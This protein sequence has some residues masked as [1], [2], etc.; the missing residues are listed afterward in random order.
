MW[1]PCLLLHQDGPPQEIHVSVAHAVAD[2]TDLGVSQLVFVFGEGVRHV[3]DA[4][5]A[6][7]ILIGVTDL[8]VFATS[9]ARTARS[10]SP[11]RILT[12]KG[13]SST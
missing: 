3:E 6:V 4:S 8:A 13:V 10:A 5:L 9:F 1:A 7:N 2:R 11:I 12:A